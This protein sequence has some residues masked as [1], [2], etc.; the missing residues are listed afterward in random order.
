MTKHENI[1][2]CNIAIPSEDTKISEFDQYQK[3]DKGPVNS[4][5][6]SL[7]LIKKVDE[8]KN[9]PKNSSKTKRRGHILSCFSMYAIPPFKYHHRK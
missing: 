6:R 2:F 5:C 7:C 1:D 3:S 9:N 4:L 8:W